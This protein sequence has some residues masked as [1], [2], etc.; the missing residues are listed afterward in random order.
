MN[1][2]FDL[3]KCSSKFCWLNYLSILEKLPEEDR[4]RGLPMLKALSQALYLQYS[5]L[6]CLQDMKYCQSCQR[7]EENRKQNFCSC[8]IINLML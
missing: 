1:E 8:E 4:I 7:I 6:L 2:Y 5:V 3:L